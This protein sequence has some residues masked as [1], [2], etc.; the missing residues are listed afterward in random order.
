MK[1]CSHYQFYLALTNQSHKWQ[2]PLLEAVAGLTNELGNQ[3]GCC[4]APPLS[5]RYYQPEVNH[6]IS[7]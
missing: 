4:I 7:S 3:L 1:S 2:G 6:D 5:A